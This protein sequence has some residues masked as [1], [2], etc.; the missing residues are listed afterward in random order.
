MATWI[1]METKV[2]QNNTMDDES[3]R[4]DL[5]LMTHK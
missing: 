1:A 3:E 4:E 2:T 5:E